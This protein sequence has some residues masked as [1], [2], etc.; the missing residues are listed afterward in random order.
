MV[1]LRCPWKTTH[2]LYQSTNGRNE[3]KTLISLVNVSRP[4]WSCA[5]PFRH[6][7]SFLFIGQ[8][9]LAD[10][11]GRTLAVQIDHHA[12]RL[13]IIRI[14]WKKVNNKLPHIFLLFLH[15]FCDVQSSSGAF[16]EIKLAG[17]KLS[18]GQWTQ[19]MKFVKWWPR[20]VECSPMLVCTRNAIKSIRRV[21]RSSKRCEKV[22]KAAISLWRARHSD[23]HHPHTHRHT[24][25]NGKS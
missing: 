6:T 12:L 5:H 11:M 24:F 13:D 14:D 7:G 4:I 18:H 19:M 25:P 20:S 9:Q 3:I 16:V 17:V 8:Q 10:E 21:T 23:T 2:L 1:C 15:L 22:C